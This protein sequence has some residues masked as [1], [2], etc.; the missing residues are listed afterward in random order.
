MTARGRDLLT[1]DAGEALE[2]DRAELSL[3]VEF[4]TGRVLGVE[5][6]PPDARL[7]ALSSAS[8][9]EKFRAA[10]DAAVPGESSS[11]SV[12]SQL[13]DDLPIALML[14]GRVFRVAGIPIEMSS[15]D[16]PPPND[17]CAGWITGGA[18]VAGHTEH[19]TPPL[20]VGPAAPAVEAGD[21]P[22][23]WHPL[24]DLPPQSTRRRRRLDVWEHEGVAHADCFFRDS[25]FDAD[26]L[27]TVVHEWRVTAA[28][29][30]DS[31]VFTSSE[32]EMGPL[33]FGE[34]PV[35]GAS[36]G[37]LVGLPVEGLRREVR[38]SFVGP[39]T[40]THLNDTLRSFEAVG[41]L[42]DALLDARRAHA[43]N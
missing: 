7:D 22:L 26:A 24:A 18:A 2:L 41:A 33:P 11:S 38:T 17:I 15:K 10:V 30:A 23:A 28:L 39:S 43:V 35:A 12:L 3:D 29:D 34:C 25:H 32:A 8:M 1:D 19:G 27:E 37:R 20:N 16:R 6:T 4:A 42:L 14:S 5:A 13:L 31:L 40:C 36:A 9:F 21:D